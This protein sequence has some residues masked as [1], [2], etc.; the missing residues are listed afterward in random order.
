MRS[1]RSRR[2]Q[3]TEWSH[4]PQSRSDSHAGV[5]I[6]GGERLRKIITKVDDMIVALQTHYATGK[7]KT[8]GAQFAATM[9]KMINESIYKTVIQFVEE[10]TC[11]DKE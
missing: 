6:Y 8:I 10:D 3:A 1:L 7:E 4:D 2:F 5:R 9:E 11:P